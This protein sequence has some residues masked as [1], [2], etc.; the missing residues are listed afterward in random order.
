MTRTNEPIIQPVIRILTPINMLIKN[1]KYT[2]VRIHARMRVHMHVRTY[3]E[4][5]C[6]LY[7]STSFLWKLGSEMNGQ[8]VRIIK[9]NSR[10]ALEQNFA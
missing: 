1:S 7:S 9:R 8:K 3:T 4:T 10:P 2:Q 6:W 5:Q